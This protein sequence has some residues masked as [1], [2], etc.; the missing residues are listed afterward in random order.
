MANNKVYE[1]PCDD[2]AERI[3]LGCVLNS[4]GSFGEISSFTEALFFHVPN[5]ILF[6]AMQ[7]FY[8]SR[9][10]PSLKDLWNHI[11]KGG[12]AKHFDGYSSLRG[13]QTSAAGST[14]GPNLDKCRQAMQRRQLLGVADDIL[15][16][17]LLEEPADLINEIAG[18]L[19]GIYQDVSDKTYTLTEVLEG[20]G[21]DEPLVEQVERERTEFKENGKLPMKGP[22]IGIKSLDEIT[23]G[24]A[25]GAL[26]GIGANTGVGKS[27]FIAR[28]IHHLI[29]SEVHHMVFS[30]E[31][32]AREYSARLHAIG[33]SIQSG[34][35][36]GRDMTDIEMHQVRGT[37]GLL[38]QRGEYC[39][40]N[41]NTSLTPEMI[42]MKLKRELVRKPIKVLII[43]HLGLLGNSNPRASDYERMGHSSRML[44]T[45]AME[46]GVCVIEAA[47]FNRASPK[48]EPSLASFRD[49]GKV[50]EDMDNAYLLS[51]PEYGQAD[52]FTRITVAKNRIGGGRLAKLEFTYNTI[53]GELS[54]RTTLQEQVNEANN[55]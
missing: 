45:I 22:S 18:T 40:L 43:D 13:Y 7:S 24:L 51:R 4:W 10:N 2:E 11:E 48:E 8:S 39:V 55:R 31:M 35:Y 37:D 47:Q 17:L 30:L 12:D 53:T 6:N 27:D 26:I 23:M 15:N 52:D 28:I 14:I 21:G 16:R 1:I 44:K 5:R 25:P 49:C 32:S 41:D 36:L 33:A 54:P 46:H 20:A 38:R 42:Q 34:R 19:S 9:H 29:N 50:E 3:I